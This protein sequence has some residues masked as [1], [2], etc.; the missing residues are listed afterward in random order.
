MVGNRNKTASYILVSE[1]NGRFDPARRQDVVSGCMVVYMDECGHEWTIE[2]TRRPRMLSQADGRGHARLTD[3]AQS[4]RIVSR[5]GWGRLTSE[6]CAVLCWRSGEPPHLD[7]QQGCATL[8]T[9]T[10]SL[11]LGS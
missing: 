9:A 11:L 8:F 5:P 4:R 3:R 2:W 10:S 6:Q 1:R 7:P